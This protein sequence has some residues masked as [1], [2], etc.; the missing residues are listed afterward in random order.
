MSSSFWTSQ[1]KTIFGPTGSVSFLRRRSI[2]SPGRWVNPTSA[3]SARSFWVMA[4]AMLYALTTPRTS[5]FL[6]VNSPIGSALSQT[7]DE[8]PRRGNGPG[9]TPA[10]DIRMPDPA[11]PHSPTA[12]APSC[13]AMPGSGPQ[14]VEL[15]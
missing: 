4:Q 1:G 8:L 12:D 10:Q 6:P 2:L 3:P 9:P 13:G 15:T 14:P 11:Q 7:P 5:P